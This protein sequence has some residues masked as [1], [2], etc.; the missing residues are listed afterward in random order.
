MGVAQHLNFDVARLGYE[1]LDKD[2]VIAKA[3]G[4]FVLGG[5]ETFAGLFVVPCDTHALAAAA[6][7]IGARFSEG[8]L[9]L[10]ILGTS[11]SID[12]KGNL[13]ADIH[14]NAWVVI[15]LLNYVLYA[16]GLPVTGNWVSLRE[17]KEGT[18]RYPLFKRRCED[19]MKCWIGVMLAKSAID[20]SKHSRLARDKKSLLQRLSFMILTW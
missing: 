7:R 17:L 1:F 11:F 8:K 18:E 9:M 2:T 6:H 3:V 16:Q 19:P 15:P 14:I 12:T 13:S 5:L 10:K 20:Q 4:S